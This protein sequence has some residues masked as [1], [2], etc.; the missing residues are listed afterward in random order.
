MVSNCFTWGIP[1]WRQK[2]STHTACRRLLPYSNKWLVLRSCPFKFA[3]QIQLSETQLLVKPI[4]LQALVCMQV[5]IHLALKLM[6]TPLFL[7][8]MEFSVGNENSWWIILHV[9][10]ESMMHRTLVFYSVMVG[11]FSYLCITNKSRFFF[12]CV[13]KY[14]SPGLTAYAKF[15]QSN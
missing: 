5:I 14:L 15:S 8:Y 13:W 2:S 1:F 4:I 9:N 12:F 11:V 6:S 7:C 10:C 3:T